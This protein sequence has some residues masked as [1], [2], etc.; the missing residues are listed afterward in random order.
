MTAP[1]DK[2]KEIASA[3][4]PSTKQQVFQRYFTAIMMDLTVLNLFAEYWRLEMRLHLPARC[5]VSWRSLSWC[6]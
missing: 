6:W 5:M 2:M 4:T 1:N 3:Q